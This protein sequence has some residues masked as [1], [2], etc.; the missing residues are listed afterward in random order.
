[1]LEIFRLPVYLWGMRK[2]ALP[3][4]ALAMLPFFSGARDVMFISNGQT[5]ECDILSYTNGM[6]VVRRL[7]GLVVTGNVSTIRGIQFMEHPKVVEKTYDAI[8]VKVDVKDVCETDEQREAL[9]RFAQDAFATAPALK[10]KSINLI[11]FHPSE[12]KEIR[13]YFEPRQINAEHPWFK[14]VFVNSSAVISHHAE[15][16]WVA[17]SVQSRITHRF[18]LK[19]TELFL[20]LYPS[21][22]YDEVKNLLLAIEA[23]NF[24]VDETN[25]MYAH[26]GGVHVPYIT[27]D[28]II[29]VTGGRGE[30]D[31]AKYTVMTSYGGGGSGSSYTFEKQG[32]TF[33]LLYDG[34]W[35]VHNGRRANPML[36]SI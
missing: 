17:G 24:K 20:Y 7:D 11:T 29:E 12:H 18:Q 13:V 1:M 6:M 30:K 2:T 25:E 34:H 28:E 23:G 16:G 19:K 27:M 4:I 36:L 32:A 3:L 9:S 35:V 33:V 14:D 10:I 26:E 22:S 8:E 31:T 5:L 15:N 21:L